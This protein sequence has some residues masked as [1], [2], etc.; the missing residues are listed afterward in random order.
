MSTTLKVVVIFL[1]SSLLYIPLSA[2][3][4]EKDPVTSDISKRDAHIMRRLVRLNHTK[5]LTVFKAMELT[6]P[7]S[8]LNCLCRSAGYGSPGTRQFYHPGTLGKF[9]DRYTCQKPGE[10]CVVEGYGC[11]RHPLPKNIHQMTQCAATHKTDGGKNIVDLITKKISTLKQ[12]NRDY[13]ARRKSELLQINTK[14]KKDKNRFI[15]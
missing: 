4:G 14:A 9:D 12:G 8:W 3:A 2:Y 5:M 10:P 7:K 6:P 15:R 13:I 11:T 1:I